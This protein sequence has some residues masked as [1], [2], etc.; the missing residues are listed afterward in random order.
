MAGAKK[1][2][3]AKA[4]AAAPAETK[5]ETPA[6]P[7]KG[8]EDLTAAQAAKRVSGKVRVI[9]VKDGEPVSEGGVFETVERNVRAEDLIAFAE[10]DG[11]ITA[12]TVD[13]QK[14]VEAA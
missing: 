4:A 2:D 3:D 10:R 8:G 6:M 7:A 14:L 11:K 1:T 5:P 9:R 12:V 13:G